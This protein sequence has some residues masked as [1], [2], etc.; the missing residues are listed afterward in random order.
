MILKINNWNKFNPRADRSNYTWFRFENKFFLNTFSWGPN[1]QRMFIYICCYAS[2]ENK[3]SIDLNVD[4][5]ASLLV[6]KKSEIL[7]CIN[8]LLNEGV[9]SDLDNSRHYAVITPSNGTATNERNE[10]NE[11]TNDI[12][13]TEVPDRVSWDL[14]SLYRKYPRKEGKAKGMKIC[15]TQIKTAKDFH[16]LASA[17]EKYCGHVALS[18]TESRFIKHFSTFMASW[19]DWLDPETGTSLQLEAPKRSIHDILEEK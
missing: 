3:E 16:D 6:L 2:Q 7:E 13:G 11:R 19:R 4:L 10:R 9:I 1:K 5:A 17:I 18:A 8:F 12:A 14:E 15:Q